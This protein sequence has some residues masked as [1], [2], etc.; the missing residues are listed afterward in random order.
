MT[1]F[2]QPYNTKLIHLEIIM[3]GQVVQFSQKK[4]IFL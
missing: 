2:I 3:S 1:D 4:A